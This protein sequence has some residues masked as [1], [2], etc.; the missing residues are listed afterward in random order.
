MIE[1]HGLTMVGVAVANLFD[2][3]ALQLPLP[4]R[5]RD[6]YALDFAMDEIR[7]RYGADAVKRAVLLD[8]DTGFSMPLLPD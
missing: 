7:E 3:S 4:F 8:R 1:E 2:A 6:D 5:G